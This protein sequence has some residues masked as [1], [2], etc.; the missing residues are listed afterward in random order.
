M[1]SLACE[2]SISDAGGRNRSGAD[3]GGDDVRRVG[4]TMHEIVRQLHHL[5][6]AMIHDRKTSIRGE[7]AKAVRHIVQRGVELAG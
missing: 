2:F 3:T 6:E 5:A 7:H 4:A 1:T